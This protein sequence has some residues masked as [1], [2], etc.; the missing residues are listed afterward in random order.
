MICIPNVIHFFFSFCH[1]NIFFF[2]FS[3]GVTFSQPRVHGMVYEPGTGE[4][5]MLDVDIGKTLQELGGIYDLFKQ[6]SN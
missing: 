1:T 3:S 6:D 5:K 2:S 4:A